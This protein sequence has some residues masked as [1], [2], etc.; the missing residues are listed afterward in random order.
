MMR[1][2]WDDSL[3]NSED[4]ELRATAEAVAAEM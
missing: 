3:A 1:Q 4:E 2:L